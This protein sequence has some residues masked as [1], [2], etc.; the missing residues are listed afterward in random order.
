LAGLLGKEPPI[1]GHGS[2]RLFSELNNGLPRPLDLR[3]AAE[4]FALALRARDDARTLPL[5]SED[6]YVYGPSKNV[7]PHLDMPGCARTAPK[8]LVAVVV[9]SERHLRRGCSVTANR[10]SRYRRRAVTLFVSSRKMMVGRKAVDGWGVARMRKRLGEL[11]WMGPGG[12][13]PNPEAIERR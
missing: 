9:W 4:P 10:V 12:A 1:I 11:K 8:A 5:E 3:D 2:L 13:I 6:A 7:V